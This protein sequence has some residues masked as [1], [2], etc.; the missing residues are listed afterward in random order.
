MRPALTAIGADWGAEELRYALHKKGLSW[1]AVS[2]QAGLRGGNARNPDAHKARFR[3]AFGSASEGIVRLNQ[4][5][6]FD[7]TPSDIVLA[8]GQRYTVIGE[9]HPV[10]L[11]TH[12]SEERLER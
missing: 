5:W 2:R 1:K 12:L 4:V 9:L 7:D 3:P 11:D 10:S 8:D 6:E